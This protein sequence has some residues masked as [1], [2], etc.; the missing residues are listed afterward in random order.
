LALQ[1][2][3]HPSGAAEIWESPRNLD[4]I[5]YFPNLFTMFK[6]AIIAAALLQASSTKIEVEDKNTKAIT[7][8]LI[9]EINVRIPLTFARNGSPFFYIASFLKLFLFSLL[10]FRPSR[11]PG[12]PPCPPS[13]PTPPSLT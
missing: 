11:P 13:S 2:L 8:A 6:T 10:T 5:A 7:S 1:L 9:D 3:Q 4:L 12:R